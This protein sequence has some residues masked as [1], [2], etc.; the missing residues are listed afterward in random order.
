MK[1]S[2]LALA[3]ALCIAWASA[4]VPP[5]AIAQAV[6]GAKATTP[7]VPELVSTAFRHGDFDELERLYAIYGKPGV[8]SALT[9]TPRVEHFWRGI[10]DVTSPDFAVTD[11]YYL[12]LDALTRKWAAAHPQS[13]MAQL[14]HAKSLISHAWFFRGGGFANTVS[15]ASW[16]AFRK[17]LGLAEAHLRRHEALAAHDSSWN[18]FMLNIGRGLDWDLD[19]LF[20]IFERGIAK[21]PDHDDLYFVMQTSLLPRWGGSIEASERYIALIT[22]QTREKRGMEMYARLYAGLSHAEVKQSLFTS[23]HVSWAKM[24]QGFEDRLSRYPHSDHRN[25][26]AYFACMAKDRETLREQLGL[27]GD[28]FERLFWGRSPEKTYEECKALAQQL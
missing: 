2:K 19:R 14:L 4:V 20:G 22:Q 8:R 23:T 26:Y 18:H 24:K 9:G 3:L 25:A 13:V 21:N 5:L 12:Q 17:Y 10:G 6:D 15:P 11:A 7:S 16:E 28:A 27:M 1:F